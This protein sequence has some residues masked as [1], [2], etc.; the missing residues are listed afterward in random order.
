MMTT[1]K[2]SKIDAARRQLETAIYLFFYE[3]DSVSIHTLTAAAYNV[4][5]D[6]LNHKG[7]S[8][9]NMRERILERVKD[10]HKGYFLKKLKE[11]ENFFKH[12]DRDPDAFLEF[13]PGQT[14][15]LIW[16]AIIDY[17]VLSGET[18]P[19]YHVFHLWFVS[20]HSN[21]FLAEVKEGLEKAYAEVSHLNKQSFFEKVL[22]VVGRLKP[23]VGI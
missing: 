16:D 15:M 23:P 14:E 21:L 6:V 1:Y 4:I 7:L 13:N 2:I 20:N 11:A 17:K 3:R 19:V 9:K 22:P 5:A 8:H 12:A 10:E 18:P